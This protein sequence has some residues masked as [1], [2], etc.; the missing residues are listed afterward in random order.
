M[1]G[2]LPGHP[3]MEPRR[4]TDGALSNTSNAWGSAAAEAAGVPAGTGRGR[5][6]STACW[7]ES[8]GGGSS[9]GASPSPFEAD[10]N[11]PSCT[12]GVSSAGGWLSR[13]ATGA[14]YS[15]AASGMSAAM[16]Q[17]PCEELEPTTGEPL[18]YNVT[19]GLLLL[20]VQDGVK[21][22]CHF[23][24][25]PQS[26]TQGV[27]ACRDGWHNHAVIQ[28]PADDM[29]KAEAGLFVVCCHK[30]M[31][32]HDYAGLLPRIRTPDGNARSASGVVTA[33]AASPLTQNSRCM[34]LTNL[35]IGNLS[36]SSS[37]T[38]LASPGIAAAKTGMWH[39]GSRK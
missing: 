19:P 39:S 11:L 5:L 17:P 4:L 33:A 32:L 20:S 9:V 6:G 24:A 18:R 37:M 35:D 7:L 34:H 10:W 27:A 8:R 36:S 28:P 29:L 13:P 25:K 3:L 26:W 16:V 23:S 1:T 14:V 15:R 2:L 22:A 21:G 31:R 30:A 38:S 12:S